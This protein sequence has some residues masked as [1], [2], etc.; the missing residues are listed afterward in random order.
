MRGIAF[1]KVVTV[2][3][4][5]LG[6]VVV[7]FQPALGLI[8]LGAAGMFTIYLIMFKRQAARLQVEWSEVNESKSARLQELV[9]S[10]VL[11]TREAADEERF[12][13][14]Y[15]QQLEKVP[16]HGE[17]SKLTNWAVWIA[18]LIVVLVG[19]VLI[20]ADALVG[21]LLVFGGI[22]LM[23]YS[24]VGNRRLRQSVSDQVGLSVDVG[25]HGSRAKASLAA[26]EQAAQHLESL[27]AQSHAGSDTTAIRAE[28]LE[29]LRKSAP[30]GTTYWA[31]EER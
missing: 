23:I 8:V 3:L 28:A 26:F 24:L 21:P 10:G 25:T 19:F 4:W 29:E 5:A 11:T 7:F 17:L 15:Y 27:H 13:L 9:E 2:V 1:L 12:V 14:D 31:D 6:L 20:V 30:F 18:G 22:A 16:S